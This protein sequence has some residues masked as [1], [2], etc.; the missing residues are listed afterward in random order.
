MVYI[1]LFLSFF[2]V[3]L[4]SFVGGFAALPLIQDQVVDVNKWLT[5]AEFTDL[6]TISQMT[7]GPIAINAATFVGIRIAGVLGAIISTL[8]C[9]LPSCIIVSL[10]GWLYFKY[11]NLPLMKGVLGGLRPAVVALIASAGVS[12]M[13]LSFWGENGISLNLSDID[14]ISVGLFSI[15]LFILQKYKSN[16]IYVMLGSGIVGGILYIIP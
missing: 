4:F 14:F 8:G 16:P 11:K 7:P 12:I 5:L 2:Q 3:G 6:I 9:I 1:K 15:A 13:V 10:L